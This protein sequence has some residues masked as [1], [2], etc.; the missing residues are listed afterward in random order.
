V[1]VASP[2][3]VWLGALVLLLV[4]GAAPA[5][6]QSVPRATDG[7]RCSFV[8]TGALGGAPVRAAGFAPA[9][10]V[11]AL[12]SDAALATYRADDCTPV[13]Q[14]A[15]AVGRSTSPVVLVTDAGQVVV[16]SNDGVWAWTPGEPTVRHVYAEPTDS[17]AVHAG[18][19]SII[20][21]AMDE[22]T[23]LRID[24]RSGRVT[25]RRTLPTDDDPGVVRGVDSI[26]WDTARGSLLVLLR[27][28]ALYSLSPRGLDRPA[29][30]STLPTGIERRRTILAPSGEL[31]YY[32]A[33]SMPF[34]ASLESPD[35]RLVL[36]ESPQLYPPTPAPPRWATWAPGTPLPASIEGPARHEDATG[37]EA[38]L[39]LSATGR[40]LVCWRRS[41][42]P[43]PGSPVPDQACWL[44]DL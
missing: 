27:A 44:V 3:L 18:G 41:E 8:L 17:E 36:L 32:A 37:S 29:L 21:A 20:V 1:D 25:R 2:S 22:A 15:H 24:V 43:S 28:G 16:V 4:T 30:R 12:Y 23:L 33:R 38:A 10:D 19:E 34:S 11:V 13:A 35:G 42:A 26:G 6:A 39:A 14:V 40:T 5:A 7:A 31:L 9:G